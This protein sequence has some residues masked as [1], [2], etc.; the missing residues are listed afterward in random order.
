MKTAAIITSIIGHTASATP[1]KLAVKTLVIF[2]FQINIAINAVIKNAMGHVLCPGIFNFP[3]DIISQIIEIYAKKIIRTFLSL[4]FDIISYQFQ[5]GTTTD[6][7]NCNSKNT[8]CKQLIY[9]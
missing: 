9:I 7:F 3:S 2:I 1:S 6:C 4:H 8:I 5:I